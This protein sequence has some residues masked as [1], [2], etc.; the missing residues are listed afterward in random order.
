[1]GKAGKSPSITSFSRAR[2]M[3]FGMTA[4]EADDE[5]M[6]QAFA[7]RQQLVKEGAVRPQTNGSGIKNI[8]WRSRN[9][10]WMVI[11]SERGKRRTRGFAANKEPGMSDEE[12]KEKALWL[13]VAFRA[14]MMQANT[15]KK[16][17]R[18]KREVP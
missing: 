13:A 14:S 15:P 2:F 7:F 10:A 12:A 5:A 8:Q 3:A 1:M 6:R 18:A 16:G 11:W 4:E 9:E 17:M